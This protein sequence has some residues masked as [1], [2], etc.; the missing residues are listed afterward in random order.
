MAHFM[1]PWKER[2][3]IFSL[4]I[5]ICEFTSVSGLFRSK[6]SK[7]ILKKK[8]AV[9]EALIKPPFSDMSFHFTKSILF[10]KCIKLV[11]NI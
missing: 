9:F 7:I 2:E 11:E 4:K 6:M 10:L 5:H 3:I 1:V 8:V